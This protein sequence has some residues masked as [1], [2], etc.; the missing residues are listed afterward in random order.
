MIKQLIAMSSPFYILL[1]FSIYPNMHMFA[2]FISSMDWF[3]WHTLVKQSGYAPLQLDCD[4]L[5]FQKEECFKWKAKCHMAVGCQKIEI[6]HRLVY[7]FCREW[8]DQV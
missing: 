3:Y 7:D 1:S 2:M 8:L 4:A 5:K 6:S